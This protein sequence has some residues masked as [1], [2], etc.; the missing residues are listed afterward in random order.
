M[1]IILVRIVAFQVIVCVVLQ[2]WL[3]GFAVYT[4][5]TLGEKNCV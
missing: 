3:N 2:I 1:V 5:L 4:L